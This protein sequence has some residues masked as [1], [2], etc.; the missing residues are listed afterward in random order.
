MPKPDGPQFTGPFY[1]G[2]PVRFQ[3][4]DHVRPG[5]VGHASATTD[6]E[7]A[8][9]YAY[10]QGGVYEVEPMDPSDVQAGDTHDW[11]VTSKSGWRVL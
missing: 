7:K 5:L 4:G 11:E 3:K 2:S 6:K 9:I 1:H 8:E 10:G